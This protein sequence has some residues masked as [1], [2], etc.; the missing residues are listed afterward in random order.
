MNNISQKE[1]TEK[2]KNM[3]LFIFEIKEKL[4]NNNEE[5]LPEVESAYKYLFLSLLLLKYP[6]T[7]KDSHIEMVIDSKSLNIDKS[8]IT[9]M[10]NEDF[11]NSLNKEEKETEETKEKALTVPS[12]AQDALMDDE[13]EVVFEEEV[14]VDDFEFS[15]S[16]PEP[17]P[18]P[19]FEPEPEPETEPEPEPEILYTKDED[20]YVR[21]LNHFIFDEHRITVI[22][23]GFCDNFKI[24]VFPQEY[25]KKDNPYAP[26]SMVAAIIKND[27]IVA[28]ASFPE[29]LKKMLD[30]TFGDYQFSVSASWRDGKLNSNIYKNGDFGIESLETIHHFEEGIY[31]DTFGKKIILDDETSATFYPLSL[32]NNDS[33]GLAPMIAIAEYGKTKEIAKLNEDGSLDL[34]TKNGLKSYC[35]FWTGNGFEIDSL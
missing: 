20:D 31:P 6:A 11:I 9:A 16:E 18:E 32:E 23:N 5:N 8:V 13:E 21:P 12:Y 2:Y 14:I 29:T 34:V 17:E 33:T 3:L 26:I 35:A 15:E 24:I 22:K 1:I 10:T 19:I 28:N 4:K 7:V 30:L 25:A 27:S